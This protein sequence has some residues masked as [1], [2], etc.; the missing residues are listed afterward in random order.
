MNENLRELNGIK[1]IIKKE[2]NKILMAT[3]N[4]ETPELYHGTDAKVLRMTEEER[5]ERERLVYVALDYLWKFYENKLDANGILLNDFQSELINVLGKNNKDALL[6][7]CSNNYS[8]L[9]KSK[10]YEYG[11][12]YV[13]NSPDRALEY[14]NMSNVYGELGNICK[15]I[16]LSS[17]KLGYDFSDANNEQQK[18]LDMLAVAVTE[19]PEPIVC[20]VRGLDIN[21]I[22][23][24]DAKPIKWEEQLSS[25]FSTGEIG[26][27]RYLGD[28]DLQNCETIDVNN[29][30]RRLAEINSGKEK[31][32]MTYEKA[33]DNYFE[34]IKKHFGI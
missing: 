20:I 34:E 17:V 12:L 31:C 33:V 14:A 7:A 3:P 24:E 2:F 8:R 26:S 21:L 13:T 9:K 23:S 11:N 32:S 10:V 27:F 5:K 6:K 16:Y 29:Y 15:I 28:Y 19:I 18:A 30:S 1:N 22:A 25:L 4:F